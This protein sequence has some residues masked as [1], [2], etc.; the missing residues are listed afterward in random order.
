MYVWACERCAEESDYH[1]TE[2]PKNAKCFF[3]D[4]KLGP[5]AKVEQADSFV[6]R[7]A[8]VD[9]DSVP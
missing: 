7:C 6:A 9:P 8:D 1:A 4:S 5:F 3:C 2:Q